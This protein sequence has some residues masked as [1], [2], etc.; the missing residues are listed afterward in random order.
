[1]LIKLLRAINSK[2]ARFGNSFIFP[3]RVNFRDAFNFAE[4]EHEVFSRLVN[5]PSEANAREYIELRRNKPS[6]TLAPDNNPNAWAVLK[7]KWQL[8]N[9]SDQI[10]THLKKE[11][12]DILISKGLYLSNSKVID[13]Y[14]NSDK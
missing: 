11:I 4:K 3:F 13:N 2:I 12:L 9:H 8:I 5:Y 14:K 10:P 1:M 6:F 7:E